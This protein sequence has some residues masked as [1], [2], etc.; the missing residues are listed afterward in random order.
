MIIILFCILL[1]VACLLEK[2]K[3]YHKFTESVES[4]IIG[5]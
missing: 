1:L 3:L 5:G 2:T 4:Q